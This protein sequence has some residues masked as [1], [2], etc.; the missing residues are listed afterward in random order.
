MG[1]H[2][3]GSRREESCVHGLSLRQLRGIQVERNSS[4][5]GTFQAK[6]FLN[7]SSSI[8]N[9]I[10]RDVSFNEEMFKSKWEPAVVNQCPRQ[11]DARCKFLACHRSRGAAECRHDWCHC[12][13]GECAFNG[14]CYPKQDY[15]KVVYEAAII[16]NSPCTR[17]TGGTCRL[18][19][20]AH[21]RGATT[22]VKGHCLCWEDSCSYIGRCYL[23]RIYENHVS[24]TIT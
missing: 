12:R 9:R 5:D 8:G 22:C 19:G 7:K 13:T 16:S 11:L 24:S 6:V 23:R 21:S 15:R 1:C 18:F 4:D 17:E 14:R 2:D 10:G 3:E 20:C